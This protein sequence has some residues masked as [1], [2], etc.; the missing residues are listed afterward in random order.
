MYN[1]GFYGGK[2][3]PFHR[4]HLNCILRAASECK[5]L[6]VVLMYNGNEE[7]QALKQE[8][9]FGNKNLTPHIRELALRRELRCYPNIEVISYDTY[10]ADARA[11]K[12]GKQEW[13]Y[14]CKDMISLMGKFDV[15]YSSEQEYHKLFQEY[16][17]FAESKILD[18]DRNIM[19]ISG[20]ALRAMPYKEAYPYLPR[21]YQQLINKKV[22]VVGTCSCGKTTLVRKLASYYNTS[23]SQ[24]QGRLICE[25]YNLSSPGLE[26]Y[27]DFLAYQYV[28]NK[29]AVEE[30]NIVAFLDTDC[31]ITTYY[32]KLYEHSNLPV[33]QALFKE[34]DYD[35]ILFVEPTNPFVEDGFR[36]ENEKQNRWLFSNRLKKIY[37]NRFGDKVKVLNGNYENNYLNAVNY[38]DHLLEGN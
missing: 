8:T 15:C 38:V 5:K 31:M 2:F 37:I 28:D 33:G 12:E 24:E 11:K 25:K 3:M 14:E 17:P 29:R 21:A 22:L 23:F 13:Y 34:I 7:L 6:Y 9:V 27:N 36:T 26:F 30:A 4:G 19:P 16:Y 32:A 20:T 18:M 10:Q 1:I 35:M